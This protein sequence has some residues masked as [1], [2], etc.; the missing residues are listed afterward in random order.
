MHLRQVEAKGIGPQ[1]SFSFSE[2]NKENAFS[3][4]Q[5]RRKKVQ[6]KGGF[7]TAWTAADEIGTPGDESAI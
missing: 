4:G 6:P 3:P 5:S 2:G 1:F 7:S